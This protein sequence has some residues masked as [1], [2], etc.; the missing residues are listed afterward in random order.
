MNI[1][2]LIGNGFDIALGLKTSYRDFL[3]WYLEQED[4]S[5]DV[6]RLKDIIR[7]NLKADIHSWADLEIALGKVTKEY[8]VSEIDSYLNAYKDVGGKINSY[9]KIQEDKVDFKIR[10]VSAIV[11]I[12]EFFAGFYEQFPSVPRKKLETICKNANIPTYAYNFINFNYTRTLVQ[13]LP[14]EREPLGSRK[15]SP[16]KTVSDVYGKTIHVHGEVNNYPLLGVD[17]ESQIANSDFR[18][19]DKVRLFLLKLQLNQ[20]L[21]E[22]VTEEAV[23]LIDNADVIVCFGLSLGNSDLSWWKRIGE[24][25]GRGESRALAIFAYSKEDMPRINA[26]DRVLI[27]DRVRDHFV[28]QA[29]IAEDEK[30]KAKIY[31]CI[32]DEIFESKLIDEK[33]EAKT[34]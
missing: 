6:K 2:F 10:N 8:R 12:R 34:E 29:D 25:L 13:A 19:S 23:T 27:R 22:G 14:P 15:L 11:E 5:P 30:A 16:Y 4:S 28:A 9:I 20:E 32:H 21:Q 17:N 31:I 33:T 26:P 3:E 1:V 24:W 7:G 18:N